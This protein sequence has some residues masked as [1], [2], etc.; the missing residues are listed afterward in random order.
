MNSTLSKQLSKQDLVSMIELITSCRECRDDGNITKLIL[1]LREIVP[2]EVAFCGLASIG[3]GASIES[4]RSLNINYPEEWLNL[5]IARRYNLTDPV[6]A[7]NFSQPSLQ[8][9]SETYKQSPPPR[10]FLSEAHD[11]GLIQGYTYGMKTKCGNEGSSASLFSFAGKSVDNHKR[12]TLILETIMPYFHEALVQVTRNQQ[13]VR[14]L[15]TTSHISVREKEVL[16]LLKDGKNSWA[17]STILKI[18]ER[19][20]NYHVGNIMEKLGAESRLHAVAIAA[21]L[22]LIDLT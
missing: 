2:Y 18:S 19:T 20:V 8:I 3:N 21:K 17:V 7:R 5:Y 10:K 6:F 13:E 15:T 11:F 4:F 16:R 22:N 1:R 14:N 9:W 12:S